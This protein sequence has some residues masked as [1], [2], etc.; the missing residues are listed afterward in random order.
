MPIS[1]NGKRY[2]TKAQIQ[3]AREYSALEYARSAGYDL[4]KDGGSYHLRDHDSMIFTAK[5]FWY[6]NSRNLKGRAV[7][8]IIEYEG[9][10]L[11]EA[12]D[13]LLG[14]YSSSPSPYGKKQIISQEKKPFEL[15]EKAPTFKRLFAYLCDTRKL[16]EAIVQE[17]VAQHRIYEGVR[18]YVSAD[19]SKRQGHC[20]VFVGLDSSGIPR[21]G[22]Q[23]GTNTYGATFKRDAQGSDKTVPFCVPGNREVDTVTVFEAAIDAISHATLV[24]M[25]GLDWH[26]RDRIALGGT[27]GVP[28]LR[29]LQSN[30][31]IRRIELCLDNDEAG[32]KGVT[33]I[34]ALLEKASHDTKHGYEIEVFYPPKEKDWNDYLK[35]V[36]AKS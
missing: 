35:K 28:L 8:F 36:T 33:S 13:I 32:H 24:K 9:K 10:S 17:L 30:H 1:K 34:Q 20:I 6:W 23:R 27:W 2:C 29:Y 4:I 16:D 3:Q 26:D 19:G 11:P 14:S 21:S 15:P 5:G 7:D 22:F 18:P 25:Q 31:H 12:V